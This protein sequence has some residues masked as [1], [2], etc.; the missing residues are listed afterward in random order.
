MVKWNIGIS[1]HDGKAYNLVFEET[2][3]KEMTVKKF[4]VHVQERT[5]V[6][7]EEMLLLQAGKQWEDS[8]T[9]GSYPNLQNG[10][11]VTIVFR[12]KGGCEPFPDTPR[13]LAPGVS[14]SKIDCAIS[15]VCEEYTPKIKMPCGHGVCAG[16]LMY[17][18]WS[19]VDNTKSEVRCFMCKTEWSLATIKRYGN[20]TD[21]EMKL[22]DEG[23]TRN[24][25]M[26]DPSIWECPGCD[27]Y[28]TRIDT[29]NHRVACGICL[30]LKKAQDYCCK[31]LRPW[32]NSNS[33]VDC[34]YGDCFSGSFKSI[35]QSAPMISSTYLPKVKFPSKRACVGCGVIVE[36]IGGC[37]HVICKLCRTEFCFV[38][39]RKKVDGCSPCGDHQSVCALAP[40]Q[41]DIPSRKKLN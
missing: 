31:C 3:L 29:T 22:L 12:L 34:G 17:Y 14:A 21:Q 37:K 4:K 39:L 6:S 1:R 23:L 13:S 5:G 19:E 18:A 28:C 25:I 9:L 8:R 36:H 33:K 26:L 2:T 20:A 11:T 41:Q 24:A 32:N 35:L 10:S 40:T 38:C 15:A 27:N 30:K 7:A 16:C